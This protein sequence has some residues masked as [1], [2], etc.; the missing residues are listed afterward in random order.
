MEVTTFHP[1]R[2]P[3][4]WSKDASILAAWNG[5]KNVVDTVHTRPTRSVARAIADSAVRGSRLQRG[6][7]ETSPTLCPSAKNTASNRPRSAVR[8]SSS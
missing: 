5:V 1:A 2:P 4:M 7:P 3:E 8:A 6:P